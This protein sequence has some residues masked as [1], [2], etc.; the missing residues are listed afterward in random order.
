MSDEQFAGTTAS[1]QAFE[2][3]R[4]TDG[5]A[6]MLVRLRLSIF[7]YRLDD[8]PELKGTEFGMQDTKGVLLD[9]A[10]DSEGRLVFDVGVVARHVADGVLGF[11][12]PYVHGPAGDQFLYLNWRKPGTA[13][14]W[15]WRRKFRLQSLTWGEIISADAAGELFAFDGTGRTGHNTTPVDWRRVP[16]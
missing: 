7:P 8:F 13:G 11:F 6:G 3:R 15:V 1:W 10:V 5:D 14:E 2:R 9:P 12:G 16:A 4:K